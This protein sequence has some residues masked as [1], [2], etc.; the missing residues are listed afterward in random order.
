M[1]DSQPLLSNDTPIGDG[2]Y[3]VCGVDELPGSVYPSESEIQLY[4]KFMI[5]VAGQCVHVKGGNPNVFI[6][7][8]FLDQESTP[9]GHIVN[10]SGLGV[11]D[12]PSIGYQ[13]PETVKLLNKTD[14][15]ASNK[16]TCDAFPDPEKADYRSTGWIYSPFY[17]GRSH[18][19]W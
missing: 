18:P 19:N 4:A 6:V 9:N 8:A 16:V 11:V 2:V 17:E 5:M 7:P 15:Y 1:L 10:F 12:V 13:F 14:F 3:V